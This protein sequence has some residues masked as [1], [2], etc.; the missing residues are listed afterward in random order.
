MVHGAFPGLA[1]LGKMTSNPAP[2]TLKAHQAREV[3]EVELA[4]LVVHALSP[5]SIPL[6]SYSILYHPCLKTP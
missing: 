2:P 1:P 3:Q 4:L 6:D 5:S